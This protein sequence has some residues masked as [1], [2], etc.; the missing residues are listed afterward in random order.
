MGGTVEIKIAQE[1]LG[2][3]IVVEAYRGTATGRAQA[4]I[5]VYKID[6]IEPDAS[7]T[8]ATKVYV[9]LDADEAKSQ[10]RE[11]TI[12]AHVVPKKAGIPV[13]FKIDKSKL[14]STRVVTDNLNL[15]AADMA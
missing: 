8:D 6:S 4:T 2:K 14:A 5:D 1:H 3:A 11:I 15:P 9:N 12:K 10:G 7:V 13:Y